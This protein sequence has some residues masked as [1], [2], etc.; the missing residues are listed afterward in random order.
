MISR[1]KTVIAIAALI[2]LGYVIWRLWQA[3]NDKKASR[4]GQSDQGRKQSRSGDRR[5]LSPLEQEAYAKAHALVRQGMATQAAN[6]LEQIGMHREAIN[7]L[8]ET[9]HYDEAVAILMRLQR[10]GRAGVLYS[11]NGFW[12]KAA[13]YFVQAG[14]LRDAARAYRE[15]GQFTEAAKLFLNESMLE[16]AADCYMK[17]AQ[18]T[19]AA[20]AWSQKGNTEKALDAWNKFGLVARPDQLRGVSQQEAGLILAAISQRPGDRGLIQILAGRGDA[21]AAII[22]LLKQGS[23]DAVRQI[24][25]KTQTKTLQ[26]LISAPDLNALDGKPLAGMLLSMDLKSQAG[27]LY[28]RYE[29]FAEA[30]EAFAAAGDQERARYCRNRSKPIANVKA[31]TQKPSEQF[32]I[33]STKEN[34]N[35]GP[36][37]FTAGVAAEGLQTLSA[38]MSPRALTPGSS[39]QSGSE[40][41]FL[42]YVVNGTLSN[43]SQT[44]GPGDWAGVENAL[45]N[46]PPQSWTAAQAVSVAI[47]TA[48]EFS[49]LCN[50]NGS[51]TRSLYTNLTLHVQSRQDKPLISKAI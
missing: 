14:Q 24:L 7:I 26:T 6:M 11:R 39:I 43:G 17:S 9:K 33:E 2:F 12:D 22:S 41:A 8:E 20:R 48:T 35:F 32:V 37:W 30:A 27:A 15:A 49:I 34:L 29:L 40:E 23:V 13:P 21:T 19:E 5:M 50:N 1:V 28:E 16:D 25:S 36:H 18:F 45:T 10:P 38:K 3:A 44:M 42:V 51:L 47:M 31:T 46:A 4:R